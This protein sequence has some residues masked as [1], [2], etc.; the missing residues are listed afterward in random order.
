MVTIQQTSLK[1]RRETRINHKDLHSRQSKS[2]NRNN[3]ARQENNIEVP[4]ALPQPHA[5]RYNPGYG[6]IRV[7]I[8]TAIGHSF[9]DRLDE[10]LEGDRNNTSLELQDQLN[11]RAHHIKPA[12]LGLPGK[13]T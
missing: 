11:L 12:L 2:Q 8:I 7:T 9:I 13:H 10:K 4:I 3:M 5:F 1:N 6:P